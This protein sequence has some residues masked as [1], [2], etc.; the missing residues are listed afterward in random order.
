MS[1]T[2]PLFLVSMVRPQPHI[3]YLALCLYQKT[4][5]RLFQQGPRARLSPLLMCADH[6]CV[7]MCVCLCMWR[8]VGNVMNIQQIWAKPWRPNKAF[9]EKKS[10][11]FRRCLRASRPKC[12]TPDLFLPGEQ[13]V[14]VVSIV[15]Y[16]RAS[17]RSLSSNASVSALGGKAAAELALRASWSQSWRALLVNGFAWGYVSHP[18]TLQG[19]WERIRLVRSNRVA[20][21][22]PALG[23]SHNG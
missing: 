17:S 22:Q 7:L 1:R 14:H 11:K 23:H 5:F 21:K 4:L 20:W 9:K 6:T 16:V 15:L 3:W 12:S 13:S 2:W 10:P 18:L 8:C 19:F